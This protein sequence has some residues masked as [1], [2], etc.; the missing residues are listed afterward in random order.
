M[1]DHI[2]VNAVS[3]VEADGYAAGVGAGVRIGN[4]GQA[5]GV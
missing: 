3:E 4:L 5:S 2:G 1:A